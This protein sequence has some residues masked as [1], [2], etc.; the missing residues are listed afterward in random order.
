MGGSFWAPG[1]PNFYWIQKV[2]IPIYFIHGTKQCIKKNPNF[3]HLENGHFFWDTLYVYQ[4]YYK[5]SMEICIDHNKEN[6]N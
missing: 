4:L 6:D 1:P 3:T 2:S 5:F